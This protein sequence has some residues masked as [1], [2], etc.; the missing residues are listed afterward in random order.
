MWPIRRK[1]NLHGRLWA[2]LVATRGHRRG[3]SGSLRRTV[4]ADRAGGRFR[5]DDTCAGRISGHAERD[6]QLWPMFAVRGA[7]RLQ[8]GRG[9][10][11]QGRLVQGLCPAGLVR[12]F[13]S[14]AAALSNT[15][16]GAGLVCLLPSMT[17]R[18]CPSARGSEE[19]II[20]LRSKT[21]RTT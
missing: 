11:Q 20:P 16:H 8:G 6:L 10:D 12:L 2:L 1:K 7:E 14:A 5:Q 13:T 21:R 3:T 17:V 18:R 19:V 15:G 4:V 9:R